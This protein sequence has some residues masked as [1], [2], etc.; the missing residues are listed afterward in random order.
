MY[1]WGNRHKDKWTRARSDVAPVIS[2]SWTG[3]QMMSKEC[4]SLCFSLSENLVTHS[5]ATNRP[6]IL[7]AFPIAGRCWRGEGKAQTCWHSWDESVPETKAWWH[8]VSTQRVLR[9]TAYHWAFL[10]EGRLIS[11]PRQSPGTPVTSW[12][13]RDYECF[14]WARS[15]QDPLWIPCKC[16]ILTWHSTLQGWHRW[17]YRIPLKFLFQFEGQGG[18][19]WGWWRRWFTLTW[20]GI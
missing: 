1:V 6:I 9:Q 8:H 16:S 14:L 5:E 20:F 11:G 4:V 17:I 10:G 19:K 3:V 12:P 13:G 2:F 18:M 7:Q 15:E